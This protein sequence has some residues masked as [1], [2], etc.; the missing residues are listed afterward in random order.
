MLIR[1][2]DGPLQKRA[3]YKGHEALIMQFSPPEQNRTDT[4]GSHRTRA[5][6][7]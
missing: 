6:H 3:E 1:A 4:R 5:A 7:R 2:A